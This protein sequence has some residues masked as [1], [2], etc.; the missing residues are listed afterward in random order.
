MELIFEDFGGSA[1]VR[2]KDSLP[3]TA[4]RL[5]AQ[6]HAAAFAN[7]LSASYLSDLKKISNVDTDS[8]HAQMQA[9]EQRVDRE[10]SGPLEDIYR[11]ADL[12][13]V[14]RIHLETTW[15]FFLFGKYVD[16]FD[17][18]IVGQE[19][20]TRSQLTP[21][22]AASL[23]GELE[24]FGISEKKCCHIVATFFQLRRAYFY[25]QYQIIGRS[26]CMLDLKARLW[27][28]IF[29]HSFEE[30]STQLWDKM[31]DFSTILLGKTGT[32][33]GTVAAAVGFSGYIPYDPIKNCFVESFTKAFVSANLSQFTSSLLESEIFGHK[34]GAFTGANEDYPGLLGKSSPYGATFL[35]E[36]GE[37]EPDIQV[38]LLKVLQER[39]YQPVGS[40]LEKRLSGR[41][42]SATHIDPVALIQNGKL[43]EDFYY[44]IATDVIVI[45]DLS[46]RIQE[47]PGEIEEIVAGV[48][49]GIYQ[50]AD[51]SQKLVDVY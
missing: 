47:D 46:K 37:V 43:R 25:I 9:I 1:M 28:N 18:Y 41:I 39:V 40:H 29:S 32:G 8:I 26:P 42:I 35:D 12:E 11:S 3:A 10:I 49:R 36:I 13:A 50:T 7:P 30:Y 14:D 44:R 21:D 19:Q 20:S 2:K 16:K 4:R 17:R 33:K 22:F 38:K 34:K 31:E 45:P 51:S 24:R 48:L 5:L 6:I 23:F 15:L 27:E